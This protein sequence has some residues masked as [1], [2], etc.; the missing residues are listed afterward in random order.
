M[1][2][3]RSTIE[4]DPLGADTDNFE[5]RCTL[6]SVK[7]TGKW[8]WGALNFRPS[9]EVV[10]FKEQQLAYVNAIGIAIDS[11]TMSLT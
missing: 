3:G 9:A 7:L 4:V 6:A 5:T 8:A 11:Q 1:Q 10:H 2:W